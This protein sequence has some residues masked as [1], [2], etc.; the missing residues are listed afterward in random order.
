MAPSCSLRSFLEIGVSWA[1][2]RYSFR[3]LGFKH[4]RYASR[5]VMIHKWAKS[6]PP[7]QRAARTRAA[8]SEEP[9]ETISAIQRIAAHSACLPSFL[10]SFIHPFIHSFLLS[11]IHSFI[12]LFIQS[13]THSLT[14][15]PAC[16]P[17][18]SLIRSCTKSFIQAFEASC[19]QLLKVADGY[20]FKFVNTVKE[21]R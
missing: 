19:W 14:Y 5:Y 16:W 12:H 6:P 17:C 2:S 13:F 1:A 4:E 21:A 3:N 7:V 8:D 10:P 20:T 11:F 9:A 15:L 18:R